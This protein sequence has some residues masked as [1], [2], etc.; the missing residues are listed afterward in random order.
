MNIKAEKKSSSN[1]TLHERRKEANEYIKLYPDR[2][3]IIFE[4]YKSIKYNN[5]YIDKQFLV[6]KLLTIGQ[7]LYYVRKKFSLTPDKAIFVFINGF[8]PPTSALLCDM[9]DYHKSNDNF[10]YITY[11]FEN[12]FG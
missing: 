6:P 12:T 4:P 10:L 3:P 2:I 7:F 1:L 8:I 9:Y 5:I 11:S